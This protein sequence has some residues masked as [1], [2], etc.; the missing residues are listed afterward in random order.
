[1]S[2]AQALTGNI[3]PCTLVHGACGKKDKDGKVILG[4]DLFAAEIAREWGWLVEPYPA[5]WDKHGK[6][7][8]PIRNREMANTRPDIGLAFGKLYRG[9]K[10]TGTGDMV[11]V[12]NARGIP[13][14]VIGE[15]IK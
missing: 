14:I 7:A 2:R 11:S 8:G 15:P 12:L 5:N 6:A 1:M 3:Y 4:A 13:V 10:L 9:S